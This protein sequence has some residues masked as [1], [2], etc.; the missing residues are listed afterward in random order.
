MATG[1][2]TSRS[3]LSLNEVAGACALAILTLAS[4]PASSDPIEVI[5][6]WESP[7]ST[8]GFDP[9]P[10]G[11]RVVVYDSGEILK[12]N[13][14]STPTTDGEVLIGTVPRAAAG[15]LASDYFSQLAGVERIQI[16]DVNFANRGRTVL[17]IWDFH[18]QTHVHWTV[19][20]HP[21]MPANG[22]NQDP[23]D[24]NA[25]HGLDPRFIQACDDIARLDI[26][27][28]KKWSPDTR[29]IIL[30]QT[31]EPSV[32]PI[33]WPLD[34]I[35]EPRSG[36]L[37]SVCTKGAT[38]DEDLTGKILS[39]DIKV[40]RGAS[41]AV[42]G[43]RDGLRWRISGVKYALPGPITY[44]TAGDDWS[45]IHLIAAGPCKLP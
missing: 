43:S 2:A 30:R 45:D 19:P 40:R 11:L 13:R 28:S 33:E 44:T 17:Q 37:L 36:R 22:S 21:C 5:S 42:I 27:D 41:A 34:W 32:V 24:K 14:V 20:G 16:G 9:W 29:R 35:V 12:L 26:P 39:P 10:A 4:A 15:Q 23:S 7:V 3:K 8:D 6:L 38:S 1:S 25:R 31:E 18:K